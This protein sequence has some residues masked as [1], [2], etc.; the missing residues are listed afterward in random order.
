VILLQNFC[1][2]SAARMRR[3]CG[4]A[5]NNLC[6]SHHLPPHELLP[7]PPLLHS[8]WCCRASACAH[9][10]AVQALRVAAGDRGVAVL[11]CCRRRSCKVLEQAGRSAEDHEVL[12][13]GDRGPR[14]SMRAPIGVSY[15][16]MSSRSLTKKNPQLEEMVIFCNQR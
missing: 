6:T 15:D 3:A 4:D 5:T 7:W 8:T 12:S 9:H 14:L 10:N 11:R 13:L 1:R 2:A 16:A